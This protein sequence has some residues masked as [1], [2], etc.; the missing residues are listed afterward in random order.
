MERKQPVQDPF[1][2]GAQEGDAD[3]ENDAHVAKKIRGQLTTYAMHQH[4]Q[5]PQLFCFQL[6]LIGPNARILRWDRTGVFVTTLFKWTEGQILADFL[7]RFDGATDQ[8][9]GWDPT[10]HRASNDEVKAVQKAFTDARFDRPSDGTMK[11]PYYRYNVVSD[12]T[13]RSFVAGRPLARS[14]SFTGRAS[15]GYICYDLSSKTI[16]FMKDAWRMVTTK[17]LLA[18]PDVYRRLNECHVDPP[19]DPADPDDPPAPGNASVPGVSEPG[20]APAEP[21]AAAGAKGVPHVPTLV[22]GGDIKGSGTGTLQT[23]CSTPVGRIAPCGSMS[24]STWC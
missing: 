24:T 19:G 8:E 6:L 23:R 13:T 1:F 18:E 20:G 22:C 15:T 3:V 21:L 11:G 17:G 2:P 5:Q 9:R 10:V 12:A 4:N 16:C 7:S 14:Q